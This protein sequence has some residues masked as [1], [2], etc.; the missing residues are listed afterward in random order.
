MQQT[1]SRA[2]RLDRAMSLLARRGTM[3]R[4]HRRLAG[5]AGVSIDRAHYLVLRRIHLEGA[6]RITELADLMGVEP[7]TISRHVQL[8]EARGWLTRKPGESDKRVSM[9]DV[10]AEGAEI[11]EAIEQERR[12]I[13][14]R[15]LAHWSDAELDRFVELFDRFA[16]D[17]SDALHELEA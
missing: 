1:E 11:V 7:S 8:L 3:T 17:L 4:F 2:E 10:T 13:L 9:A 16:S 5:A 6:S 14:D 12:R 15:T